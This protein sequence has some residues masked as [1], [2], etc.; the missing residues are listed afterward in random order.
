[1]QLSMDNY[2]ACVKLLEKSLH[3]GFWGQKTFL[4]LSVDTIKLLMEVVH[5]SEKGKCDPPTTP[6]GD[7]RINV[8]S[9][10]LISSSCVSVF[11]LVFQVSWYGCMT[12]GHLHSPDNT[13]CCFSYNMP[14]NVTWAFNIALCL[15]SLLLSSHT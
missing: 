8:A 7:F 13:G 4:K 5:V 10:L 9:L 15:S 2:F 1:M 3:G 14:F 11:T 6:G 12:L